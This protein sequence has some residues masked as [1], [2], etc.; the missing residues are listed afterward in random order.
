[1][2]E[3]EFAS[4]GI[5]FLFRWLTESSLSIRVE[6]FF[7]HLHAVIKSGGVIVGEL[8]ITLC[9]PG[10]KELRDLSNNCWVR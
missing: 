7:R 9:V 10:L 8:D 3:P 6:R 4:E 1:M 5:A 2:L